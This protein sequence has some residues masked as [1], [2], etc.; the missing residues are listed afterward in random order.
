MANTDINLKTSPLTGPEVGR[1]YN[2]KV[3]IDWRDAVNNAPDGE[4]AGD[5][6]TYIISNIP[7]GYVKGV[8]YIIEEAWAATG[9]TDIDME[10]GDASDP[11]GYYESRAIDSLIFPV[12]EPNGV[13]WDR[14]DTT[15]S[16]GETND[17]TVTVEN[18]R[19]VLPYNATSTLEVLITPTG[20]KLGDSTAG[21]VTIFADIL[22]P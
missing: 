18:S 19:N 17:V 2:V 5:T 4:S 10:I 15:S 22:F 14:T 21:R 13:Y 6:Q 1:G 3:T 16:N 11:N 20:G 9:A 12:G 8:Y 7:V